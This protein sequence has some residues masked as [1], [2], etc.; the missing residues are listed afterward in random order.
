[1]PAH[2]VAI[3]RNGESHGTFHVHERGEGGPARVG[4]VLAAYCALWR[5]GLRIE[6]DP[7]G[8]F[9]PDLSLADPDGALRL[10]GECARPE[11]PRIRRVLEAHPWAEVLVVVE[12]PA[13]AASAVSFL[14]EIG[15]PARLAVVEVNRG[16]GKRFLPGLRSRNVLAATATEGRLALDWNGRPIETAVRTRRLEKVRA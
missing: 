16:L 7:A 5:E 13:E 11:I 2:S 10:W 14:G 1:M 8:R 15:E 3:T 9:L 6:E 4:L 12:G